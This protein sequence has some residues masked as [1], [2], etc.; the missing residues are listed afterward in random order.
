MAERT[1]NPK[2]PNSTQQN[3]EGN[4]LERQNQRKQQKKETQKQEE[5]SSD[6]EKCSSSDDEAVSPL[7]RSSVDIMANRAVAGTIQKHR[8]GTDALEYAI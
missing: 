1:G 3:K 8:S 2:A 7:I 5:G 4:T 6:E